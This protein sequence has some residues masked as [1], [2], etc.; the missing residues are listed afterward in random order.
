MNRGR[1]GENIFPQPEDY[2]AFLKIVRETAE[3]WNL[4]IAVYCLMTNH[5]HLLV[6]TPDGNLSR[7]MRHINGVYTQHFNRTHQQDGPLFRGRYKAILVEEDNYLLEVMRYI[8]R[9]PLS[10]GLCKH[11]DAYPWSSHGGY[12]SSAKQWQWL[13]KDTLLTMLA[14]KERDRKK[15]YLAFVS[16]GE[17]EEITAF[18][19]MKKLSSMLGGDAF[20]DRVRT[21]FAHLA[22]EKEVSE[23]YAVALTPKEII[24]R[25]CAYYGLDAETLLKARRGRE[26]LPRDIA[27][28]LTRRYSRLTLI[29]IGAAF[30]LSNYSSVSSV[31]QRVSVRQ[32]QDQNVAQALET[33]SA[34]ISKGQT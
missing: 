7:G 8:H 12:L 20:K 1:R 13:Y 11:L 26:N 32:S 34:E 33:L 6:Y 16:Q 4:K 15:A 27:I 5:Y 14:S 18:Y 10:A 29:E 28:Y 9:N 21:R 17:S 31:V 22:T 3:T 19:A 30:N 23:A 2:D 25:V 24:G